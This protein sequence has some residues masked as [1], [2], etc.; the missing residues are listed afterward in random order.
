MSQEWTRSPDVA[1]RP[2]V[3][4]SRC[5]CGNEEL[6]IFSVDYL[7]CPRCQTLL[8]ARMPDPSSLMVGENEEGLYGHSYFDSYQVERLGLP[9][10]AE[11]ARKDLTERCV[12]WLRTLLKYKLPPARTLELG[13]THGGF[14][15]L[16]R[17]AGYDAVGLELSPWVA[18][19]ARETFGVPTLL[20]PIECQQE[21][22]RSFDAV[23][24]MDV[25]EHLPDPV[26]TLEHC[27]RLLKPD[28]VLLIQT[29][30]YR[31]GM[32]LDEMSAADDQFMKMLLPDQHLFL[33]SRQSV[34]ELMRR[35]G[36][37][38]VRF[39]P[40]IFLAYDMFLAATPAPSA[41][42]LDAE[43]ELALDASRDGRLVRAL[44]DLRTSL[45]DLTN[46]YAESE[47]DRANRLR[48]INDQGRRLAEIDNAGKL[49]RAETEEL[50]TRLEAAI[51][52]E[53]E[54]TRILD[55]RG[56][57]LEVRLA[58]LDAAS[59]V[60][61]AEGEELL[62]RL[63]ASQALCAQQAEEAQKL[64]KLR[65]QLEVRLAESEA[66]VQAAETETGTLRNRL[67]A[68]AAECARRAEEAR[69]QETLQ[70]ELEVRL[71]SAEASASHAASEASRLSTFLAERDE[72]VRELK[73]DSASQSRVLQ[74]LRSD[75]VLSR[76]ALKR[77]RATSVYRLLRAFGLWQWL[78]QATLRVVPDE[79]SQLRAKNPRPLQR[80]MVDLTPVLP[81]G[82][83]G[84]AKVMTLE[85]LR[86]LSRL[87][88]GCEFTLLTSEASHDELAHLDS[89]NM[90]RLC[91]QK[92]SVGSPP[93]TMWRRIY[94]RLAH[95]LIALLR[96]SPGG[97]Y[98]LTAHRSRTLQGQLRA[99]VLFCPFTAP[100]FHDARVPSVSVIY[101]LQHVYYP[102]FF[103]DTDRAERD[104]NFR[105]A[106]SAAARLV[107]ISDY[108]RQT[109]LDNNPISPERVET[110]HIALPHRVSRPADGEPEGV[111]E[112][113]GLKAAEFLIY[114]AN[115]WLHKN[116]EV[117]L[118]AF[119]MY[120]AGDPQSNLKLALTG[121][122]SPR[123]EYLRQATER[124]GLEQR[125]VFAGFVSD[126][127]LASLLY[128]ARALIFPSLYE[129]FGMPVL[130]AMA[131]GKPV[132]CSKITSLPEIAG[133]AAIL[134]DPRKPAEIADA[135]ARLV[136]NPDY[137]SELIARGR[138]RVEQF[139][140]P[141]EM[142][143]RYLRVLQ[144]ATV[145]PQASSPFGIS[146][147]YSDRW[148]RGH[149][150]VT[151]GAGAVDRKLLV[152]LAAPEWASEPSHVRVRSSTSRSSEAHSI[153]QGQVLR[154]E[155][156]LPSRSGQVDIDIHPEFQPAA[157]GLGEDAR[158]IACRLI[159]AE[160]VADD[161]TLISLD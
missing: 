76:A 149:L 86:E 83:N 64:D 158:W 14:V 12:H 117:L 32:T 82:Q 26:K 130:E 68:S 10:I 84:G 137:A 5:W 157:C 146:G 116:H 160:I 70:H 87:A 106:C 93:Q 25:L 154:L 129:G 22:D 127:D 18:T 37:G 47:N 16:L 57:E 34:A 8:V 119:G 85:L 41:I 23:L 2:A 30:S 147:V 123:M 1:P 121:A 21:P 74:S 19:F 56:G 48:V 27:V 92:G 145:S 100:F 60:A 77:I 6:E 150:S 29:P 33:F 94:G 63:A 98:P 120:C 3:S 89:P 105:A 40:A 50:R 73:A 36:A 45:D 71:I 102:N 17:W 67:A 110:I 31:E 125:V 39:E 4:A 122:P 126:A 109:V 111:L 62:S 135:I 138:Q 9:P 35:V 143:K 58:E 59:R 140:G 104:R 103:N 131:A 72:R 136:S 108:V 79:P 13:S 49:S 151:F 24:L 156:V 132:L 43:R 107:C 52:R 88:R 28:G 124:M 15:A 144:E 20:G 97:L 11:R 38:H 61:R 54:E 46:R 141:L 7:R 51:A 134:F 53:A 66:A 99:D 112:R 148:A 114:P 95:P 118:T 96:R 90:R 78:H 75:V 81:G 128:S 153:S 44:L 69:T 65:G 142:A 161:G 91:V 101:D 159:S 42:S 139:G 155:H 80:V 133:G 55:T 115:F 152:E 113:H